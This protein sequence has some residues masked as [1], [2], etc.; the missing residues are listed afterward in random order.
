MHIS[1]SQRAEILTHALPYIREYK[2]KIL[3]VKYGGGAMQSAGLRDA[4]MGDVALLSLIGIKVVLVHGGGPEITDLLGRLGKKSE[5]VDGLRVTDAETADVALMVLAGKINKGLVNAIN[6]K[7]GR[8]VGLCG[9]DAGMIEAAQLDPCLGY[10]G[11]ITAV[12]PTIIT[13][14][15]DMG[16]IPVVSTVGGAADREDD[17]Q[18][19]FYNINADTAA[20]KLAGALG[21]E[22]LIL[23]T[24]VCGLLRDKTD[25]TSLI[26]TVAAGEIQALMDEGIISGGMIP[27]VNCCAEN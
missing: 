3:V 12:D 14:L 6:R 18:D 19:H 24:D 7:G 17:A 5:F 10:V 26:A 23:M 11:K 27:K 4:V 13:D 15:L 2:D 16:Y 1:N 22:S 9:L 21:A 20:A 8:A 25:P